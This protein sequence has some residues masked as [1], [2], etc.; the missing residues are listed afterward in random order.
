MAFSGWN[1][2]SIQFAIENRDNFDF[3]LM[4]R[5][6]LVNFCDILF[7]EFKSYRSYTLEHCSYSDLVHLHSFRV[8]CPYCGKLMTEYEYNNFKLCSTCMAK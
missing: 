8:L 1:K 4:N 2:V 7:H 6:D 5:N 3:N